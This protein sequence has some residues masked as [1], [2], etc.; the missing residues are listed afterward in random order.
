MLPAR[1]HFNKDTC[2]VLH[3]E[4]NSST[5]QYKLGA[6]SWETAW[7]KSPRDPAGDHEPNAVYRVKVTKQWHGLPKGV[8][9][10]SSLE[11]FKSYLDM[12]QCKQVYVALLDQGDG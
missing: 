6:S 3:L 7:Q 4:R 8:V 9:E 2:Q 10:S 5:H 1:D 11:I 12:I